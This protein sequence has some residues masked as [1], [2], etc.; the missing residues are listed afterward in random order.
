MFPIP[1]A[2]GETSSFK[3]W[4]LLASKDIDPMQAWRSGETFYPRLDFIL[5]RL[6][7]I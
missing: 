2:D 4:L 3:K 1:L 7:L 6:G 5:E